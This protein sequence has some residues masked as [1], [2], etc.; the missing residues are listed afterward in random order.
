MSDA[1][2]ITIR[3]SHYCEKARW[4]LDRTRLPYREEPQI[5]LVSRLVRRRHAGGTVPQLIHG[6]ASLNDSR[7]ILVHAD[8]FAGG[9]V[10]Y[11]RDATARADVDALEKRFD[12]DLGTHVRRWAYS[13]LLPEKALLRD[14]WGRGA[15]AS[16]T[17][18]L[19]MVAPAARFLVTKAYKLT[20][21]SAARSLAMVREIFAEVD[22]RL[23]DGRRYLAGDRFTAADLTFAALSA[24]AI[25]PRGC[26]AVLPALS[27]TPAA[28]RAEVERLRE[29][30]A[31]RFVQRLYDTERDVTHAS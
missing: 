21:A 17:F 15:S 27:Q 23:R 2:F 14:L 29:T 5:P 13:H 11:P 25:F 16:E 31:G 8:A 9:G 24:P 30:D 26:R 19:P 18:F 12:A 6:D 28:M 22:A 4:G 7:D 10:L 3:L 1:I 20:P